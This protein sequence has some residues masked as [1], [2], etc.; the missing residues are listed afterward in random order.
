MYFVNMRKSSPRFI[1]KDIN[2]KKTKAVILGAATLAVLGLGAVGVNKT[3]AAENGTVHP[4]MESLIQALA[5][6][7]GTSP[8]EVQAV[9]DEQHANMQ[10][11]FEQKGEERIAAAIEAG[12]LTQEQADALKARHEEN[13][14]FMESLKDLTPEARQEALKT[15]HEEMKA[16]AESEGIELPFIG[17]GGKG[18]GHGMMGQRGGEGRFGR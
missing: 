9:F 4:R 6:K 12:K 16:W 11:Q 15:H 17:R 10:A 1:P 2:M 14:A 8:A 3:L 5:D 13:Q 18:Q 7:F